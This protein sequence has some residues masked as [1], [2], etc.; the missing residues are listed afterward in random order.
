MDGCG[1]SVGAESWTKEACSVATVRLLE[2]V[3]SSCFK[4]IL[5]RPARGPDFNPP[6]GTLGTATA[7]AENP[8]QGEPVPTVEIPTPGGDQAEVQDPLCHSCAGRPVRTG[9]RRA[10]DDNKDQDGDLGD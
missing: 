10:G 6:E 9:P 3:R 1:Q 5:A 8:E 2:A 4:V 7:G